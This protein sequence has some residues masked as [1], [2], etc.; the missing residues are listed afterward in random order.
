MR[1]P[2]KR[3]I[4]DSD[5]RGLASAFPPPACGGEGQGGGI[6]LCTRPKQLI[7]PTRSYGDTP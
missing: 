5:K 1:K 6:F 7:D 2:G 4:G 3:L